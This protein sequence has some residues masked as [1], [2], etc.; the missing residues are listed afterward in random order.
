MK[1]D[2]DFYKDET[3]EIW[4]RKQISWSLNDTAGTADWVVPSDYY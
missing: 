2:I 1:R 3:Q 4:N